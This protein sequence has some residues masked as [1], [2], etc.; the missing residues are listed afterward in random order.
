MLETV[1]SMMSELVGYERVFCAEG[2]D[3]SLDLL[4]GILSFDIHEY[5]PDMEYNGWRIPPKVR[6]TEARIEKAG[7]TIYDGLSHPLGVI[8][9][10]A[11]FDGKVGLDE[12]R[13]HLHF[14][15]RNDEAIPYHFRQQYRPWAR[16][17]GFCVTK[18]FADSLESG[19][20]RVVIG[21]EESPNTLK[22]AEYTHHG[23]ISDSF[24]F[25]AHLDHPGMANDD[26]AGCAVGIE[27]FRRLAGLKTKYTYK[28]IIVPEVIGSEYY[29][30]VSNGGGR[31]TIFESIFLEMLGSTTPLAL[32][33][34]LG[35]VSNIETAVAGAL[36][37]LKIAHRTGPFKSVIVNDEYIWEA[38]GIPMSSLSRFPYPNYHSNLDDMSII[39]PV[40]LEEAVRVLERA[41]EGLE[42][43]RIIRKRFKGTICASNPKYDLYIDPGQYAFGT[44]GDHDVQ[45]KRLLMDLIPTLKGPVTVEA[46]AKRLELDA[47]FVE[48]YLE[49]WADKGLVDLI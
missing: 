30:G 16:D 27:L 38:Y 13:A 17:W 31:E 41:V 2:Y 25:V 39:D 23:S 32:Q 12:L 21:T 20:Y 37:E 8:S 9:L 4:K 6:V 48:A 19:E 26:L 14:D 3:R 10:T 49:K 33:A 35:A 24:A 11:P 29:L 18:R 43:T 1:M 46:L 34:S 15:H 28:L 36:D 45:R 7:K 40:S 47:A 5:G 44:W 42:K 22:V